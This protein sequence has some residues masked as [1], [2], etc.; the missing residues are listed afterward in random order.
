MIKDTIVFIDG[1]NWYH[2]TKKI[3]DTK[4]ID[5]IKLANFIAK[6]FNLEVKQIRYYNSVPDISENPL[7]YHKHMEFLT[8]L[9]KQGIKVFKRKLQKTSNAEIL[10]QKQKMMETL[11]LCKIC[12]PLV[13]LNCFSCIG[14]TSKKEKGIDVKIAVDMIRKL[15]IENEY[16]VCILISGDADFIPAMQTIKSSK[17]EVITA[18]VY[19]GYSR[20]LRDGRFRYFYLSPEDLNKNCMKGYKK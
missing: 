6:K 3:V 7:N 1:N 2:N 12:Y 19:T 8:S 18:S 9:E 5:F 13:K 16:E 20:E 11:D 17:K 15:L 14:N 10:K 4:E